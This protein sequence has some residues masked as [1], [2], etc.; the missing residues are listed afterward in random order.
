NEPAPAEGT[1]SD[2]TSV[3]SDTSAAKTAMK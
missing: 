3:T 2:S 1:S